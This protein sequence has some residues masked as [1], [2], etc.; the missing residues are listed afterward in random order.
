MRRNGPV[1]L[2]SSSTSLYPGCLG[3]LATNRLEHFKIFRGLK[4][5]TLY[6][7]I[8]NE[9]QRVSLEY[10][11]AALVKASQALKRSLRAG[12]REG[13]EVWFT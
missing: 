4:K 11:E 5:V 2:I 12:T 10:V 1:L 9:F 13:V 3:S 7:I 8:S 6:V